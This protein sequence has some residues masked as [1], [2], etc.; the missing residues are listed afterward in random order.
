MLLCSQT[1]L[2]EDFSESD[3][4]KWRLGDINWIF[5]LRSQLWGTAILTIGPII[6]LAIVHFVRLLFEPYLGIA[7]VT[8]YVSGR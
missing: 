1:F 8:L 5:V 2:V 6:A 3:E 7:T 4:I